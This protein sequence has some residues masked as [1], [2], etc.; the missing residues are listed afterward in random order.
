MR[1]EISNKQEKD[2]DM[3]ITNLKELNLKS[4]VRQINKNYLFMYSDLDK[5]VCRLNIKVQEEEIDIE[6]IEC[7]RT[8]LGGKFKKIN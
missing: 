7:F 5:K 8:D 1:I 2:F 4:K 3:F 6:V